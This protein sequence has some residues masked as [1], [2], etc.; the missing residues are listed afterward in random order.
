MIRKSSGVWTEFKEEKQ[1]KKF[2]IIIKESFTKNNLTWQMQV[3]I[4][5]SSGLGQRLGVRI[6]SLGVMA[7]I[8]FASLI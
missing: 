8:I 7:V 2:L 6:F 3:R 4:S 5:R 1:I